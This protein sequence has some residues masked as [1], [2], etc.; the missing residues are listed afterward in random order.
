MLYTENFFMNFI[1]LKLLLYLLFLISFCSFCFVL[2]HV[3][4]CSSYCQRHIQLQILLF[5]LCIKKNLNSILNLLNEKIYLKVSCMKLLVSSLF[6]NCGKLKSI[7]KW[8][9]KYWYNFI[10]LVSRICKCC[11]SNSNNTENEYH[12]Y[13]LVHYI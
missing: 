12:F 7:S 1:N 6:F 8:R 9:S 2:W 11:D 5:N 3:L 10:Y 13:W 4:D